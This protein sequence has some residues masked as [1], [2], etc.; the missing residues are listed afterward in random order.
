MTEKEGG[1][2]QYW[3]T[4]WMV[5]GL[6]VTA[7]LAE[8]F[9]GYRAVGFFFL[10]GVLALGLFY[11][12]GPVL[13]A[14]FLSALIWDYFFIPPHFTLTISTS[15]D[16]LMILAYF[17]AAVITGLLT[18]RVRK[19]QSALESRERRTELLYRLVSRIAEGDR[20]KTLYGVTEML[21]RA[22]DRGFFVFLTDKD[23]K[24]INQGH[25]VQPFHFTDKEESV[26]VWA[27][28][29]R[30]PAGWSTQKF[31]EDLLYYMPL[32]G[33]SEVMGLLV[34][35]PRGG[36]RFSPEEEELLKAASRQLALYLE[37]ERLAARSHEADLLRESEQL[38][39]AL[40]N[41][42]SHELRTPLTALLGSADAL[43]DEATASD[44]V[45]RQLLLE[46]VSGAG[47]RLNRVIE[48]LLDMARLNSGVLALKKDWHDPAELARLVLGRLKGPLSGHRLKLEL[49]EGLP[50][51]SVDYRLMEHALS[52]LLL[53]AA[54]Y[55]PKGSVITVSARA[56]ERNVELSVADEGPGIPEEHRLTVFEKFYRLPGA[57]AGGTGLG[58]YI[59]QS[60]LKAHAGSA[61]V[62]N[63][64]EGGAEFTLSLPLE[65]APA[66]PS[67][68][69]P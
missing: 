45:R 10:C 41:S 24:L 55:A 59:T 50:L 2:L 27:L 25:A 17:L 44:P 62:S 63:V 64:A 39:Q 9:L 16:A 31:P 6:A 58:L 29:A 19:N 40:L 42:I 36:P 61:R 56:N 65:A 37:R 30:Q 51:I 66:P 33:T 53:N 22:L 43:K 49:P 15:E 18:H 13:F 46:D 69:R 67:E 54:A 57:S 52:N 48:N 1:F 4:L 7:N 5:G 28:E 20:E 34:C 35:R 60:L 21:E 32:L 3:Y 68:A 12:L 23:S 47:E 26:A 38:H 8:H 11:S 14:A